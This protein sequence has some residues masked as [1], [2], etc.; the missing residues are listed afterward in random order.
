MKHSHSHPFTYSEGML[1]APEELSLSSLF[2][3]ETDLQIGLEAFQCWQTAA[4]L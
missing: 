1:K 4:V 3:I 2:N